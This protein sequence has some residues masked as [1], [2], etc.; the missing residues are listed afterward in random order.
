MDTIQ[1]RQL[2]SQS[3]VALHS[4]VFRLDFALGLVNNIEED[5]YMSKRYHA[6]EVSRNYFDF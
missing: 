6:K 4:M 2:L 5:F 1:N 3:A